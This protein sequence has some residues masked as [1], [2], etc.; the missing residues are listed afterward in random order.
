MSK[1]DGLEREAEWNSKLAR[2]DGG[3]WLR[4]NE[5]LTRKE[6][7]GRLSWSQKYLILHSTVCTGR[8]RAKRN[9]YIHIDIYTQSEIIMHFF[10]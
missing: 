8:R 9:L 6:G 5:E 1:S 7:K 3:P 2:E 4:E 10:K